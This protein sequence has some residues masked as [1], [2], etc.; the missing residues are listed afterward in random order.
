MSAEINT[1]FF[2]FSSLKSFNK[3]E[4]IVFFSFNDGECT[5]T[6][7]KI[8]KKQ[9]IKYKNRFNVYYQIHTKTIFWLYSASVNIRELL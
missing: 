8:K 6:A 1:F 3:F 7:T 4:K 2:I 5:L 9:P